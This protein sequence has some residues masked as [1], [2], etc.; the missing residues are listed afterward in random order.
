M[1]RVSV[2]LPVYNAAAYL[3]QALDSLQAQT[4]E[5]LEVIIS[6]NGST[7]AT[8]GIARRFA[9][10]DA[11]IR[12]VRHDVNRGA[13]F[14]HNFVFEQSV[15]PYFRWFAYD[16][17]L[18][19]GC[20]KACARLLDSA[21]EVVLTWPQ[22]K[23]IDESGVVTSD[24]R[25][26][27]HFDNASPSTRLHSLL[28]RRTSETLLHM[29]HPMYGLMRRDVL[30]KTRLMA[31]TP[32]ADTILL[33]ELALRGEWQQVPERLFYHR[34]HEASSMVNT[35][36][37]QVAAYYDPRAGS[38]FPMPQTRL[39]RGYVRAVLTTPLSAAERA[40]CLGVVAKWLGRDHQSRVILG[41]WRIRA[42]Q[43]LLSGGS[44]SL[45]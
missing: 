6:D 2:G 32:S 40:R 34:R 5:D 12:Y 33:V 29:C 43:V 8:P 14:N 30:A 10:A 16:D 21:P 41:E 28:G 11:R 35:T 38:V 7:D 1:T 26:D 42:R 31:S 19:P 44:N 45:S 20:I 17:V 39:A 18:D 4:H 22:T 3:E 13:A 37:E 15:A 25:T 36:A 9:E 27:L 24:Y 23:I